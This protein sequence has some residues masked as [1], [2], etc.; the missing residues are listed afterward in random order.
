MDPPSLVTRFWFGP[1]HIIRL[2][3]C[4]RDLATMSDLCR[5]SGHLG[6]EYARFGLCRH[7]STYR[8]PE[9]FAALCVAGVLVTS[10]TIRIKKERNAVGQKLVISCHAKALFFFFLS[11]TLNTSVSKVEGPTRYLVVGPSCS[12]EALRIGRQCWSGQRVWTPTTSCFEK[13]EIEAEALVP[14]ILAQIS[15]PLT[16][17]FPPFF[18]PFKVCLGKQIFRKMQDDDAKAQ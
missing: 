3:K 15:F 10:L 5:T 6:L 11:G 18:S 16:L 14:D 8:R 4:Q 2:I 9:S 12:M 7:L 13:R 17:A 1:E